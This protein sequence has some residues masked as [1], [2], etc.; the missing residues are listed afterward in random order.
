MTTI[1]KTIELEADIETVWAKISDI[2][3]ISKLIGFLQDSKLTGDERVCT[4]ADGGTLVENVVSVD[5]DL[6]R[7]LYSITQ[8]PLNMSFHV[9]SMELEQTQNGTRFTWTTDLQPEQAAAQFE[10]LLDM[11]CKDCNRHWQ[12]RPRKMAG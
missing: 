4:L 2:G 9:A 1:R 11:A 3:G 8:S 12:A 5:A 6:H 10:P 7:V